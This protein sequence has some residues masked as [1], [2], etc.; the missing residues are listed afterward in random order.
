MNI[1]L[2]KHGLKYTSDDV[3]KQ[4]ATLKKYTKSNIYC[5]TEDKLYVSVDCIKIPERPNLMKWWNKMHMFRDDFPLNGKCVLFD[6]DITINSNPFVHIQN[7]DWSYPTFIHEE[8]K[9]DIYIADHAYDTQLNSSILAWD[10]SKPNNVWN[11]FSTNIDYYT[12]KYKGIDRFF[13]HEDIKWR[14]FDNGIFKCIT[15]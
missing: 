15:L 11:K 4:A 3:N 14:S 1:I 13:W 5:F 12:R 9:K 10:A 6:L 8:S 2:L 7:I